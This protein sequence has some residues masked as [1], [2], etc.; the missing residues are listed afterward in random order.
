MVDGISHCRSDDDFEHRVRREGTLEARM[1]DLGF[2]ENVRTFLTISLGVPLGGKCYKLVAAVMS[3][4]AW[5]HV[6]LCQN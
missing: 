3:I 4:P 1:G 5:L 2:G 6:N